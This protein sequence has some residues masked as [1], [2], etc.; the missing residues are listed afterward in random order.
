M[1]HQPKIDQCE[2]DQ[3]RDAVLSQGRQAEAKRLNRRE[4]A[5]TSHG[6][7]TPSVKGIGPEK[8]GANEWASPAALPNREPAP[9]RFFPS[10][11]R[12][13]YPK[14]GSMEKQEG[15]PNGIPSKVRPG[16][17]SAPKRLLVSV[18][19]LISQSDDLRLSGGLIEYEIQLLTGLDL[20]I[21][22]RRQSLSV[23]DQIHA[24]WIGDIPIR[25]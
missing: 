3:S 23:L 14:R 1:V 25:P 7:I 9:R 12:S 20:L 18:G 6:Q 2:P 15:R 19:R 4:G 21:G 10:A 22:A 24:N 8:P 5:E 13:T 11:G 17:Q 16:R